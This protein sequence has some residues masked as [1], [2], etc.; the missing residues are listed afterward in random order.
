MFEVNNRAIDVDETVKLFAKRADLRLTV[1][2]DSQCD[3]SDRL[4]V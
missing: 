4:A 2:L 3:H 1:V